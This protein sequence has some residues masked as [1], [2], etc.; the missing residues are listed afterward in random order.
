MN[1]ISRISILAVSL[2][3]FDALASTAKNAAPKL[4]VQSFEEIAR[5]KNPL[6]ALG[7]LITKET[8]VV[9]KFYRPNCGPCA[10]TVEDFERLAKQYQD[11]ATFVSLNTDSFNVAGSYNVRMVPHFLVF[12]KGK[13][14]SKF[15]RS[16]LKKEGFVVA[17]EN[18]LSKLGVTQ[19]A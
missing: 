14:I 11:R 5:G 2:F 6:S 4:G 17:I 16:G 12:H 7:E 9:I 8:P 3:A 1:T 13:L 10:A 18:E 19:K 15:S